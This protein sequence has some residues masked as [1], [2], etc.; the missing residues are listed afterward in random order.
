MAST[1]AGAPSPSGLQVGPNDFRISDLGSN[2]D[3]DFTARDPHVAYNPID[4]EYLAVW[5]GDEVDHESEILGQ[6]TTGSAPHFADG[7][8][9]GDSSAW[10]A[11]V[12]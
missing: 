7:F 2:G 6:R 10:S 5:H 9:S 11:T 8:E 4:H 3:I 12:P 1:A